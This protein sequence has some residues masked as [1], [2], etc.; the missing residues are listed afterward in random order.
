MQERK[1][2]DNDKK[3]KLQKSLT[4]GLRIIVDLGFDE[5]MTAPEL[6]SLAQQ[7][8]YCYSANSKCSKPCH[9]TFTDYTGP[10]ADQL[11]AQ[12]ASNAQW[13][14]SKHAAPYI[15]VFKGRCAPVLLLDDQDV[16]YAAPNNRRV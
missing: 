1:C 2:Q 9:L 12:A 3:A 13:V 14:K 4:D 11:N 5:L 10:S 8:I 15:D 16:T 6:K 7:L